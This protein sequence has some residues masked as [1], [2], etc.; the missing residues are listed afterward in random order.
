MSQDKKAVES[1]HHVTV[2]QT[3]ERQVGE[4]VL[5]A[6]R[7][8]EAVAALTTLVPGVRHDRV[9]SLPLDREQV[10]A[11]R[12]VLETAASEAADDE[13]ETDGRRDGFL[14]FH[15]VLRLDEDSD[16]QKNATNS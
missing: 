9:V 8:E 13:D 11:I 4:H 3:I 10:E 14:G 7:E 12:G 16:A 1:P 6:L 15:T 2:I 5:A